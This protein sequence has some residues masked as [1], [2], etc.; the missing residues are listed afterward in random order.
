MTLASDLEVRRLE[1]G[2]VAGVVALQREVFPAIAGRPAD[3][4]ARKLEALFFESPYTRDGLSQV[5]VDG[6]GRLVGFRGFLLRKW[7]Y[8]GETLIAS[9]GTGVSVHPDARRRGVALAMVEA[10]RAGIRDGGIDRAFHVADRPAQNEA[11]RRY[12]LAAGDEYLVAYGFGWSAPLR[13]GLLSRL[14]GASARPLGEALGEDALD[15]ERLGELLQILGAERAPH[16][17]PDPHALGWL[18][19][20]MRDYPSRGRLE[21]RRLRR[22]GVPI[23]FFVGYLHARDFEVLAYGAT[24][25]HDADA[26][27]RL[28]A[29][30]RA[31]GAHRILGRSSAWDLRPLLELGARIYPSNPMAFREASE[32]LRQQFRAGAALVTGLEGEAWI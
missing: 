9:T 18:L 2:D 8:R 27:A 10:T 13:G 30:A 19:D 32:D 5:T 6:R 28:F 31:L 15:A 1:P 4:V 11:S 16:L 12:G 29:T 23:G 20:Y 21:A 7:C 3:E 17:A 26:R 22:D 24:R 14:R 25:E